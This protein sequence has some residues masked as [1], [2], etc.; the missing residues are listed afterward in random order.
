MFSYTLTGISKMGN[1]DPTYGQAYWASSSDMD[2]PI[3]FNSMT[4]DLDIRLE[5]GPIAIVAEE[6]SVKQGKKGEF[7]ALKKVRIAE[8]VAEDPFEPKQPSERLVEGPRTP[9]AGN[10]ASYILTSDPVN[11]KLDRIE[12]KLDKLLGNDEV[13]DKNGEAM[14]QMPDDFL[15]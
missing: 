2:M 5:G 14:P 6:K 9:Q 1:F 3:K 4:K 7:L 15:A 12:A 8:K 10:P 13:L 11:T